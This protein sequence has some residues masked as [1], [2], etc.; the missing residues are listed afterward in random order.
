MIGGRTAVFGKMQRGVAL[1]ANPEQQHVAA[2]LVDARQW[3]GF[4]QTATE[5]VILNDRKRIPAEGGE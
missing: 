2:E 1:E 5:L 4:S 3:E